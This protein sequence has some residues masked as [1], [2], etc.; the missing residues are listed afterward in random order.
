MTSKYLNPKADVLFKLV[1]GEHEDLLMSL[2]NA[3]LPLPANGQ[4]ESLEY[5]TP[6]MVPENPAK[7]GGVQRLPSVF[8]VP[9]HRRCALQGPAGAHFHR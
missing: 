6:Q 4:I 7:K 2:L 1:F 8:G 5:L 9:Q 3:L